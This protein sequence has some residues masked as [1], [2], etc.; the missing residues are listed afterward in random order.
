MLEKLNHFPV[1]WV[2]G[3]K[4]NKSHFIA[5][6]DH[7]SDVVRDALGTQM[8]P[9]N[10]GL[11]P[12]GNSG[13]SVKISLVIDNHKLLRVKVEECHAITPNGCRIDISS[14]NAHMLNLE[15]PYPEAV[16]ELDYDQDMVLLANVSVNL[17]DKRPFGDPDPNENPPRYPNVIP[18]FNLN[19]VPEKNVDNTQGGYHLTLG[20]III[21]RTESYLMADYI[22]PCTSV[23]SHQKLIDIHTKIDR[24]FGQLELYSVQISQ[25]INR[26]NQ[27]NE[28]AIIILDLCQ[29]IITYLGNN[30][31]SFR[32]FTISQPPAYMFDT[33]IA[34]ARIMKN[35]IDSKSGAGKEE[36][37]NYIAEWCG[38]SQGDFE[39]MFTDLV[40]VGYNHVQIDKTA[41]KTLH[42]VN[43]ISELFT[44]L[45][46]L[47]YI[48]KR[49][50]NGIFVKERLELES[51]AL[52]TS[53]R[54]RTFLED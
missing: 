26:K 41:K 7:M 25:K 19:L 28:L 33:V 2:D 30:I 47:D 27:S 29:K 31:N 20:K 42:F 14:N 40:N 23:T 32:W 52:D 21:N 38:I 12:F 11:L 15:M 8:T 48:G 22:P 24:F 36:L 17:F 45:N 53:K 54:N 34:L 3:M 51:V 39:V 18:T 1:N 44:T 43:V 46:H 16:Y 50:D 5:M 49:K 10:Y 6:Q 9:L 13:E 35:Y 4:I 37:L